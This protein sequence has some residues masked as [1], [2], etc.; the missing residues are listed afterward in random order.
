M[1]D[2]DRRAKR[3][4]FDQTEPEPR[5]PSRFDRRSRSP[6]SRQSEVTRTRSP[7][8]REPR[9]PSTDAGKKSGSVDPAAAAAAAAAKINAQ[10][11]AKKGIQ[12]VDVPP[13]RST[14]SPAP[15][16]DESAGDAAKLNAEIYVADGDYIKDIEINDLRNRYTLTKGSTQKMIKEE[17]GADVTTRGN[18]YPDKS[19]ASAA[20]PPLYLHVTST[21]KDGLEKAVALID[22]LMQKELPNLVDERRF[23]RREPEPVERDEYGRRKWPEERI[24]IDLDPIPG[25]NLRAQVV[26]QG[27]AYVKHIQQKTRCKVQIKGRGSGFMEPSTGRESDEPMYLHV[28]GP[29]PNEVQNAKELCEDLLGNVREQYQR[30]KENPPQHNYGGYGQR[31]DRYNNNRDNSYGGG[32]GG[33]SNHNQGHHHQ[34]STPASASPSG[35]TPGAAGASAS[36]TDYSAQYAQYYGSDPYAAY[37]GYQN[38]VAYYQYYQQAAAAQQQ[39]Q[40]QSQSPAPPPPPANEAPP[41][42]PPGSGSPPPPPPGGSYSAVPPPPGL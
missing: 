35:Q 26:G 36:P 23:R 33:Y 40:Q 25:F 38:Y 30:F 14:S 32:Y 6:S 22:D 10:L 29:D 11:Q 12:H 1:A 19:M 13:I 8:S 17:T 20:N 7:L 28:A 21:N 42:P 34:Q 5:R 39:Q 31:G 9:S 24:P 16:P 18:Y 37:G 27:G 15:K 3:S 41:P 2:D 4:R